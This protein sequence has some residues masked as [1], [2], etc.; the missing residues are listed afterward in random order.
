MDTT[1]AAQFDIVQLQAGEVLQAFGDARFRA[2]WD[3]LYNACPWATVFQ[4][5]VFAAV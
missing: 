4:S 3:C 2:A 5:A 1:P